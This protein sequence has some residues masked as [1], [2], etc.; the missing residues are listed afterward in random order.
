MTPFQSYLAAIIVFVT[1]VALSVFG[2]VCH[3]TEAVQLGGMMVGS[4]LGWIGLKRPADK[5]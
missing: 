3:Q 5:V 4:A 2:W 1:G